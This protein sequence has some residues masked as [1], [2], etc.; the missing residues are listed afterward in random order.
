MCRDIKSA[1]AAI[2]ALPSYKIAV[3]LISAICIKISQLTI[4][5][6]I[7]MHVLRDTAAKV[8]QGYPCF[9]GDTVPPTVSSSSS[10]I[11]AL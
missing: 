9:C 2:S 1:V 4:H 8:L 3:I 5:M 10:S 7:F 6:L 11:D